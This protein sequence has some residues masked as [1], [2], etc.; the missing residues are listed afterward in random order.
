MQSL[1]QYRPKIKEDYLVEGLDGIYI[2][3]GRPPWDINSLISWNMLGQIIQVWMKMYPEEFKDWW[4]DVE[5]ELAIERPLRE[6]TKKGFKKSIG[7]P[8][9]LF[10]MIKLYFPEIKVQNRKFIKKC[11]KRFPML[12]NSNFT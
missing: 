1:A 5:L 4:H 3:L 11:I 2:K 10:T 12:H 8:P 7:F 6:S 9:R